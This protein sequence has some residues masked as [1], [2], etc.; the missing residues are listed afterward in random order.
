M[1][2]DAQDFARLREVL[3]K[4]LQPVQLRR[5]YGTEL[6]G[7]NGEKILV[8]ADLPPYATVTIDLCLE[9]SAAAE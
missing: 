3:P 5:A 8:G 7:P 4:V 6:E 2:R 1:E 9:A